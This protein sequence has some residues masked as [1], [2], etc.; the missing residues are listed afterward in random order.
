MPD[1][2][3]GADLTKER[4]RLFLDHAGPFD[5]TLGVSYPSAQH[6]RSTEIVQLTQVAADCRCLIEKVSCLVPAAGNALR[7]RPRLYSA[8]ARPRGSPTTF[9]TA[10]ASWLNVEDASIFPMVMAKMA[11]QFST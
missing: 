11:A 10:S 9:Q 8:D 2:P 4:G 3:Q 5:V 6:Q 1:P 7:P